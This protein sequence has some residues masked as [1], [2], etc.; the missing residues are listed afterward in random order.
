MN[1]DIIVYCFDKNNNNNIIINLKEYSKELIKSGNY[2][3]NIIPVLKEIIP[4]N[5]KYI[6]IYDNNFSK[7][8]YSTYFF[9]KKKYKFTII[10]LKE[11]TQP[12]WFGWG[13]ITSAKSD[14]NFP[15]KKF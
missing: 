11:S 12:T 4:S 2:F 14:G 13:S 15:S 1:K 10:F 3:L 5:N 6:S 8:D 7:I 9:F